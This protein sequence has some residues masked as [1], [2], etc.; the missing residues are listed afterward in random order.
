[1][2]KHSDETAHTVAL[3]T[4]IALKNCHVTATDKQTPTQFALAVRDTLMSQ[5]DIVQ[6]LA[7]MDKPVECT[8]QL[9]SGVLRVRCVPFVESFTGGES[10]VERDSLVHE[11]RRR[12]IIL[13]DDQELV[14]P[15]DRP[16]V[17]AVF[18]DWLHARYES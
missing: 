15:S 3:A 9:R 17:P 14:P 1:M 6:S 18:S 7:A 16:R 5:S 10:I 8:A 13:D 11:L 2:R 12:G 4:V